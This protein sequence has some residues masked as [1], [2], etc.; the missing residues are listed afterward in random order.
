MLN[1]DAASQ[2][3]FETDTPE[4]HRYRSGMY[5]VLSMRKQ[6]FVLSKYDFEGEADDHD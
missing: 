3:R 6:N 1:V 2:A 5:I 4:I